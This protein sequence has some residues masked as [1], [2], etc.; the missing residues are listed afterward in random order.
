MCV[1][2]FMYHSNTPPGI[3]VLPYATETAVNFGLAEKSGNVTITNV[4][5]EDGAEGH[6]CFV[7][8]YSSIRY[9]PDHVGLGRESARTF[10]VVSPRIDRAFLS[11][12]ALCAAISTTFAPLEEKIVSREPTSKRL[13]LS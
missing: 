9:I 1:P 12:S 13:R 8:G 2:F 4:E 11:E 10:H 6:G 3:G 5:P 7:S